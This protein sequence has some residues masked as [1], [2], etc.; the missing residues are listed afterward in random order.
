MN[1]YTKPDGELITTGDQAIQA[2]APPMSVDTV[3]G[4]VK[5]IQRIMKDVMQDKT[6]YGLVPG[7]GDKKVLLQ[8]GAQK[9]CLTF[10]L[11][12]NFDIQ[13]RELGDGHREY[14]VVCTLTSIGSGAFVGQGVGVCSTHESKYRWRRGERTCPAC[15]KPAIIPE[16]AKYSNQPGWICW[17]KK[18]GCGKAFALHDPVIVNQNTDRVENTDPADCYNTCL[19]MAK[20]RA[21]V[22]ATVTA[23]AASDIFT[24]DIGDTDEA[25][26]PEQPRQEQ[27]QQQKSNAAN[28]T[29]QEPRAPNAAEMEHFKLKLQEAAN[30]GTASLQQVWDRLLG[31][32]S[33]FETFKDKLKDHAIKVDAERQSA[34]L[35]DALKGEDE[36]WSRETSEEVPF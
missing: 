1:E 29:T 24:Q 33:Y 5:L 22:D 25:A 35:A 4:Q 26:E 6:H 14:Q 17:K 21:H 18:D 32:K 2:V 28:G 30:H 20:K 16:S 7:C 10:R 12:T 11:A 19:K 8:P 15:G 34:P 31:W 3:V 9:L 36:E 23:L 13:T 27:R